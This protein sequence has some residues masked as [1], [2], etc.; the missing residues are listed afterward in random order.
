MDAFISGRYDCID[1]VYNEFVNAAVQRVVT[2]QFLPLLP[3]EKTPGTKHKNTG[4][5]FEPTKEYIMTELIPQN[6]KLIL[7]EALLD[8][9]A[10]ENGARMTSMQQ[11]TDNATDLIQELTLQYNKARQAAITNELVEIVGGAEALNG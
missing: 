10:S 9:Y 11:A 3:H 2:E 1:I 4:F 5:V 7:Y 6:L 8:S